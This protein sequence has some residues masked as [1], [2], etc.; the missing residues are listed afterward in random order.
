MSSPTCPSSL[1]WWR[2]QVCNEKMKLESHLVA[3]NDWILFRFW[4]K[5]CYCRRLWIHLWC[6][7]KSAGRSPWKKNIDSTRLYPRRPPYFE[8]RSSLFQTTKKLMGFQW[9][10]GQIW[11]NFSGL[12]PSGGNWG[13]AFFRMLIGG[14]RYGLWCCEHMS[15]N[16]SFVDATFILFVVP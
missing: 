7:W 10:D 8:I 1:S 2:F 13:F 14:G 3:W 16:Y 6:S 4:C 9:P 15:K 12:R 11:S 5:I